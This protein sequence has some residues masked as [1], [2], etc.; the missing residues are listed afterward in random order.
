MA[1]L[2]DVTR[3]ALLGVIWVHT[4]GYVNLGQHN[5]GGIPASSFDS[6]FSSIY[7]NN[8]YT[9][10]PA[11]V[12]A[13]QYRNGLSAQIT[14][15]EGDKQ[16]QISSSQQIQCELIA[17]PDPVSGADMPLER[18]AIPDTHRSPSPR[19]PTRQPQCSVVQAER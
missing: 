3:S 1:A 11:A 19:L 15:Q 8:S 13:A 4:C 18:C 17:A 5:I 10:G 9:N 7:D 6:S 14:L 12:V 16:R 2:R